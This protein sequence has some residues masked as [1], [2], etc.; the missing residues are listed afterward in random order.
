MS[1]FAQFLQELRVRH[2]LRQVE[3]AE[4][5]G[6]EQSYISALEIGS[7]GPPTEHFVERLIRVLSISQAEEIKLRA[8]VAASQRKLV[9]DPD[10]PQDVFWLLKELRDGVNQLRPVQVRMIREALNLPGTMQEERAVPTRRLKRRKKE[11][12]QM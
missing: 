8:A 6:Y 7:K 1:P 10:A 3:L 12:A 4:A 9:I 11:E 2:G 5:I